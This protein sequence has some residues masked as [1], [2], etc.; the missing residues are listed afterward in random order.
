MTKREMKKLEKVLYKI[1]TDYMVA[2]DSRG[3]LDE[4]GCDSEDFIEVPVWG[5][6]GAMKKAYELGKAQA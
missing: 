2:V 5:I 6:M 1:A 4:K 3:S